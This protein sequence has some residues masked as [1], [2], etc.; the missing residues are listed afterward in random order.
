MAVVVG[1]SDAKANVN[2]FCVRLWI[3]SKAPQQ[4]SAVTSA[5]QSQRHSA[6]GVDVCAADRA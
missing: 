5:R 2:A 1:Q 6:T 3:K 4:G